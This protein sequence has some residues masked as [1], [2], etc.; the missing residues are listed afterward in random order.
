MPVLLTIKL[1]KITYSGENIGNDLTFQF[2][3]KDQATQVKA[4]I[5]SGEHESLD[6]VLFQ[7]TFAEE[8]SVNL[9]VS[10]AITEED[11]VFND[12]GSGSTRFNV[13]LQEPGTQTHSFNAKVVASGGDKGKTAAFTF[14]LE[15]DVS[16]IKIE[17]IS[18][19]ADRTFFIDST[20]KMPAI[21]FVADTEP[22]SQAPIGAS[23]D[24]SIEIIYAD[25]SLAAQEA[26]GI[27]TVTGNSAPGAAFTPTFGKLTGDTGETSPGGTVSRCQASAILKMGGRNLCSRTVEFHIRGKNPTT[28]EINQV[29]ISVTGQG[30][31]L[32][33]GIRQ[34]T[35]AASIVQSV[36]QKES[37]KKQFRP[38]GTPALGTSEIS[39][40]AKRGD[41]GIM[42]INAQHGNVTTYAWNWKE[43]ASQGMFLL[44]DAIR[45]SI[46]NVSNLRT[47]YPS[48]PD[49]NDKQHWQ[50]ALSIFN[51][52]KYYW[53]PNNTNDKWIPNPNNQMGR[54]YAD[55]TL[56]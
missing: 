55:S 51:S 10:V 8:I 34:V 12:A 15:A 54:D 30:P 42:Q 4:G 28:A 48:L 18:P 1:K 47:A 23:I 37:G 27:E 40:W 24:W 16:V 19:D 11:I 2:N 43:N 3:V 32:G 21:D 17:I 46:Q 45:Q 13:Q 53:I 49:L 7:E 25:H 22:R 39:H 38:D 5:S 6:K 20:P 35:M 26:I 36:A 52:G 14:V 50:N 44:K 31:E 9:P 33:G 56:P 29:L 41:R